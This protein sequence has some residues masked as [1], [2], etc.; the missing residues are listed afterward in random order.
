MGVSSI[1]VIGI[2]CSY[3]SDRHLLHLC[4]WEMILIHF[5]TLQNARFK[6]SNK[7]QY[8]NTSN[9]IKFKL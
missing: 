1:S 5:S 3:V 9:G 7:N 4:K 8:T 6:Q 2:S